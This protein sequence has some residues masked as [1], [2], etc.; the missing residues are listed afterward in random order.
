MT[1]WSEEKNQGQR[2]CFE[3]S[4][5]SWSFSPAEVIP[6][7]SEDDGMGRDGGIP[8]VLNPAESFRHPRVLP[9]AL[10]DDGM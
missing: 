1:G 10:Q 2:P 6:R 4:R 3:I 5:H 7:T 9:G 8:L